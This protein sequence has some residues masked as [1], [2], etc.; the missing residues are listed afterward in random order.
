MAKTVKNLGASV[1]VKH[2][3]THWEAQLVH[4][5][6]EKEGMVEVRWA[7]GGFRYVAKELVSNMVDHSRASRSSRRPIESAPTVSTRTRQSFHKKKPLPTEEP[8]YKKKRIDENK[9]ATKVTEKSEAAIE[10][11]KGTEDEVAA[12]SKGKATGGVEKAAI[13]WEKDTTANEKVSLREHL[14]GS[15]G[16]GSHG[17]FSSSDAKSKLDKVM[18]TKSTYETP[19]GSVDT[20]KPQSASRGSTKNKSTSP[21]SNE[22][23]SKVDDKAAKNR[24][25]EG[26]RENLQGILRTRTYN[27]K[28][29]APKDADEAESTSGKAGPASLQQLHLKDNVGD[30]TGKKRASEPRK[31]VQPRKKVRFL[32]DSDAV[33]RP[34]VEETARGMQDG[35]SLTEWLSMASNRRIVVC[36]K[37][38][39]KWDRKDNT[40]TGDIVALVEG[41]LKVELSL[42]TKIKIQQYLIKL[43]N[44]DAGHAR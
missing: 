18:L 38:F 25:Q 7:S 21:S 17:A 2:G 11:V 41:K 9:T 33:Q 36:V 32:C 43:V 28:G 4:G 22:Q 40:T 14:D 44:G 23:T 13:H 35:V 24:S 3:R 8:V 29:T 1:H 6:V 15:P 27:H 42:D 26:K 20:M 12:S 19:S 37:E 30:Q 16:L 34:W 31:D 5:G 39:Y 10:G